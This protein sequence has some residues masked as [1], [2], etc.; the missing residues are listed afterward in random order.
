M[1]SAVRSGLF[2]LLSGGFGSRRHFAVENRSTL[3]SPSTL[4]WLPINVLTRHRHQVIDEAKTMS[5]IPVWFSGAKLNF[6]ENMLRFRDDRLAL[7]FTGILGT[8]Y[9]RPPTFVAIWFP[10][11]SA[12]LCLGRQSDHRSNAPGFFDSVL[13][14]HSR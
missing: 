6:A 12:K 14:Q 2:F 13:K 5:D 8:L 11:K 7:A 9:P 4:H 3:H 1:F 10:V